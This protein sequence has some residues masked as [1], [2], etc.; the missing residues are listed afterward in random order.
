[1]SIFN[2]DKY[3]NYKGGEQMPFGDGRGPWWALNNEYYRGRGY[4]R[5]FRGGYGRY[6]V[7][8]CEKRIE[9]LLSKI[10]ELKKEI[11]ELKSKSRG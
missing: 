4:G 10:E 8:D 3:E 5:G 6:L 7:E 1:M 9:E 2:L 11:E